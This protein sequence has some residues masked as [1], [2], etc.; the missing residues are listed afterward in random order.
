MGS[1]GIIRLTK[2]MMRL[3][4]LVLGVLSVTLASQQWPNLRTT[5]GLNPF[6]P[7]FRAQPRTQTEAVEAGWEL[8]SSCE[9]PFLGHRFT[10]PSDPSFILIFDDA[11]YI[12]GV[13]SVILDKY[14]EHDVSAQPVYQLD[15]WYEE[16]AWFTTAYFVDP[17]I[18]CAGGRSEDEW[19]S[20]GTGDRLL[21]QNGSKDNFITLPL[22]QA[23]ADLDPAWFDHL[24]FLG[25]GDHYLG[26]DY[27]PDQDCDSVLPLQILYDQG[28]ITGFVFQHLANIPGDMWEHPD[29]KVIP[30]IIDRPPTCI[31]DYVETIGISTMHHYFYNYPW[32]TT[33]PFNQEES[34]AGYRKMM[35]KNN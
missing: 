11:G 30:M 3:S 22:T 21:V 13:Q 20:Q 23:E 12:A 29:M 25:M 2:D 33:C 4:L 18:I 34:R 8:L 1:Q 19:N 9:G 14:L 28:V 6:G 16:P 26:F 27:T 35:L 10:D 5:F 15:V 7:A 31:K 17:A 24:C 32:L